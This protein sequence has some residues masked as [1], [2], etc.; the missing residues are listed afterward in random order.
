MPAGSEPTSRRWKSLHPEVVAARQPQGADTG[1]EAAIGRRGDRQQRVGAVAASESA[2]RNSLHAEWGEGVVENLAQNLARVLPGQRGLL[3]QDLWRMRQVFDG[4]AADAKL[5]SLVR[6][7]PWTHNLVILNQAA[8]AKA[9]GPHLKA[10]CRRHGVQA[11]KH[12]ATCAAA[13]RLKWSGHVPST[14]LPSAATVSGLRSAVVRPAADPAACAPRPWSPGA[15]LRA[16][17]ARR[18]AWR[19]TPARCA[20]RR[21]RSRQGCHVR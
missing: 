9:C 20:G 7:V 14:G 21:H 8:I 17:C 3:A 12:G 1:A 11:G 16:R 18:H 15:G 4:Y 10:L 5:S 19:W 13:R 6:V 2:R